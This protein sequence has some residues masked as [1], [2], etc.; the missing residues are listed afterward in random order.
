MDYYLGEI[1]LFA[2]NYAPQGWML[3]QGQLLSVSDYQTLYSLLGTLYGGD[4]VSTFALPDLRGRVPIG[5]GTGAGLTLRKLGQ[6]G[7]TETVT[8]T[9]EQLPVHHHTFNTLASDATTGTLPGKSTNMA[10]AQATGNT[11]EYLNNTAPTPTV[12]TLDAVT[13]GSAGSSGAHDN[14]MP[15]MPLSYIIAAE[16]GIYPVRP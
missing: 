4:G 12:K 13:Y 3:C 5:Q 1:R 8:L 2:G 15:S 6:A 11:R 7:G 9:P 16:N 10:F 14:L